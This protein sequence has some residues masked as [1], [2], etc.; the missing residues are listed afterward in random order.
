MDVPLFPMFH[1]KE[2]AIDFFEKF[3]NEVFYGLYDLCG[4]ASLAKDTGTLNHFEKLTGTVV[5]QLLVFGLWP[6]LQKLLLLT[7]YCFHT[8]IYKKVVHPF[9]L[10]IGL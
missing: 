3:M 2:M 7:N 8:L 1:K 4:A 6:C 5:L 9:C 10:A